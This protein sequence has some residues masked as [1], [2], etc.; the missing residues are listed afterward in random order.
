MTHGS[1]DCGRHVFGVHPHLTLHDHG[2]FVRMKDL[3]RV[4]D[5]DDGLA[6]IGVDPIENRRHGCRLTRTRWPGHDH[7]PRFGRG[8]PLHRLGQAELTERLGTGHD[9][10]QNEGDR[11]TL[12]KSGSPKPAEIVTPVGEVG[13][14]SRLEI[15]RRSLSEHRLGISLSVCRSQRGVPVETTQLSI[16]T[17]DRADPTLRWMSDALWST[18]FDN[19]SSIVLI[20]FGT[21]PSSDG[22][23]GFCQ[24]RFREKRAS[25]GPVTAD[26]RRRF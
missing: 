14:S 6:L 24:E 1:P 20:G 22:V 13:R 8:N 7:E 3:D 9:P 10:A 26:H 17:D 18:A 15:S 12:P 21:S 23:I 19:N 4:F 11:A 5:G 25:K 16:D 2:A